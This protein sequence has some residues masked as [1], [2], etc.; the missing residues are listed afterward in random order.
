[1]PNGEVS[2]RE[3]CLVDN[4]FV[5]ITDD[6]H[7]KI[8]DEMFAKTASTSLDKT[9]FS[10][11]NKQPPSQLRRRSISSKQSIVSFPTKI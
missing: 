11:I 10:Q 3:Y 1:M 6:H 5:P 4:N 8:L 9:Y 2:Y 7:Q